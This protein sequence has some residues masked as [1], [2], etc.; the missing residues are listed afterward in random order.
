MAVHLAR[1]SSTRSSEVGQPGMT[2]AKAEVLDDANRLVASAGNRHDDMMR[3][4][5][6]RAPEA[7]RGVL[8]SS[9]LDLIGAD[10]AVPTPSR[11]R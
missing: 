6:V 9:L 2:R 5:A 1:S 11:T 8:L 7:K 3:I 4:D 10:R